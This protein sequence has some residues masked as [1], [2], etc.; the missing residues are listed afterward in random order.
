M[1]SELM[2]KEEAKYLLLYLYREMLKVCEKSAIKCYAY[3][4]TLLGAVKFKGMI[5]WDDDMDFVIFRKD[6]NHFI[7]TCKNVLHEPVK[8]QCRETD[9]YFCNEYIKLCFEDELYGYSD[10]AIDVF[11][12]DDTNPN[13]KILR[14]FQD[15]ALLWLY[16]TKRYKVSKLNKGRPYHPRNPIKKIILSV[17]SLMSIKTIDYIHR[18]IMTIGKSDSFCV[19]WGS[20][21]AYDLETYKK[22]DWNETI[23]LAF[24]NTSISAP[25]KYDNLLSQLY[26]KDYMM[27]YPVEKQVDHGVRK[28]NCSKVDINDIKKMIDG[29]KG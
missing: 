8:I 15:R 20:H 29:V 4:G 26:G 27:P 24:E 28:L 22:V 25:I 3:Q 13:S 12:F 1:S 10:V 7:E 5:P 6:Y 23:P 14:F 9:P 21:Y 19:N 2:S 17:T 16:Y 18:R 11:V